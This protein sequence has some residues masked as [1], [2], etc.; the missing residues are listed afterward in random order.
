MHIQFETLCEKSVAS[1]IQYSGE[2][3]RGYFF[4]MKRSKIRIIRAFVI[5]I[6]DNPSIIQITIRFY[7]ETRV[8][9]FLFASPPTKSVINKIVGRRSIQHARR[10]WQSNLFLLFDRQGAVLSKG[11]ARKSEKAGNRACKEE[12]Q[13]GWERSY[14]NARGQVRGTGDEE[15]FLSHNAWNEETRCA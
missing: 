3:F 9:T 12:A 1:G 15:C 8:I 4:E 14:G 13:R 7:T 10:C 2:K 5:I 11:K 6:P